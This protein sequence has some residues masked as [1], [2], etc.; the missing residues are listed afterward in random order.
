MF[1]DGSVPSVAQDIERFGFFQPT[2]ARGE[3]A[4]RALIND[5]VFRD[6][7]D[8]AAALHVLWAALIGPAALGIAGRLGPGEHPD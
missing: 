7:L 2:T 1:L 8:P 4:I 3:A 6:A 5:G